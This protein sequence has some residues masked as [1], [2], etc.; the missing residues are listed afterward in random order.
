MPTII[1]KNSS[2]F[3]Y[4]KTIEDKSVSMVLIDPPYEVLHLNLNFMDKY[5]NM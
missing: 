5:R 1:L 4:L 2:C 3:E